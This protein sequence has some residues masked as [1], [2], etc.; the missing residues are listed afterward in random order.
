MTDLLTVDG[1]L[2]YDRIIRHFVLGG[3]CAALGPYA[4]VVLLAIQASA[5]QSTGI[6]EISVKRLSELTSISPTGI[7]RALA[8]LKAAGYI[9]TLPSEPGHSSRY[10][11]VRWIVARDQQTGTEVPVSW[12]YVP[13][14]E[15]KCLDDIKAFVKTGEMPTGPGVHIHLHVDQLQ[16]V[17]RGGLG[18]QVQNKNSDVLDALKW[19][20]SLHPSKW[21]EVLLAAGLHIAGKP[22]EEAITTAWRAAIASIGDAE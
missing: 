21:N 20:K 12:P 19:W 18:I 6:A 3:D 16:V 11:V 2:Y 10:M 1:T 7:H 9:K 4:V 5:R 14:R 8:V 22:S 17:E 13:D 15:S